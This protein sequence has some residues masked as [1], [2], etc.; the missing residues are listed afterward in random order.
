MAREHGTLSRREAGLHGVAPRYTELVRRCTRSRGCTR[1]MSRDLP[2]PTVRRWLAA[3]SEDEASVLN[4]F[5][6]LDYAAADL[7]RHI[8]LNIDALHRNTLGLR[9][10]PLN[11]STI[12]DWLDLPPEFARLRHKTAQSDVAR[13][14][15]LARYGGICACWPVTRLL[16]SLAD[17]ACVRCVQTSTQTCSWRSRLHPSRPCWTSTSTCST[18][19]W[20]SSAAKAPFLPTF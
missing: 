20:A 17:I 8:R 2:L 12:S 1:V 9:V 16:G 18:P 13:I 5:V 15:L 3:S 11:A 7:P 6:W 19:P 10:V 4:V 14:G